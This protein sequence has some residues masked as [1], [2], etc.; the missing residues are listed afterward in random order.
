MLL[1]GLV[2]LCAVAGIM[3][4]VLRSEPTNQRACP[5]KD[6]FDGIS[7]GTRVFTAIRSHFGK[8]ALDAARKWEKLALREVTV[9]E[10]LIFMCACDQKGLVPSR[11]HIKPPVKSRQ[12]RK[13]A[14]K[15]GHDMV[16][17]MIQ[18]YQYRLRQ[19]KD[20]IDAC[21]K[22]NQAQ[23][24][25]KW[26]GLLK[27]SICCLAKR[28]QEKTRVQMDKT[29]NEMQDSR[30]KNSSRNRR[31]KKKA[32]TTTD[33]EVDKLSSGFESSLA[34]SASPKGQSSDVKTG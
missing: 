34:L 21:G 17:V 7:P 27:Q 6:S 31:G 1:S 16:R 10:Q 18:H 12:A 8:S 28:H 4:E 15:Y 33:S 19:L 2:Q 23:M 32:P 26:F 20:Q 11:L 30:G 22:E 14:L 25:E 3:C 5:E 24:D 29:L 9:S 13:V